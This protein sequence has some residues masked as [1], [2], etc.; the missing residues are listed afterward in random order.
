MCLF[1]CLFF[2][3]CRQAPRYEHEL[4]R[5]DNAMAHS[6]EWVE[7]KERGIS[8]LRSKLANAVQD[9]ER[10]WINKDLYREYLE[11]DADSAGYYVEQNIGLAARMGKPEDVAAAV[12]FLASDAARYIT[13]QV[14]SVDGGLNM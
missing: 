10:Y 6:E 9:E 4:E 2:I 12:A 11:Y 1:A 7:R 8:Q 13:G 5:L 14:L 3:S